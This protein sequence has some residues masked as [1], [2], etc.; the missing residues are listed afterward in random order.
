MLS[1]A[2]QLFSNEFDMSY[3]IPENGIR[4]PLPLNTENRLDD[5]CNKSD[6]LFK[7][8]YY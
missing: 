5:K 6:E 8:V 2:V 3:Q 1:V 7:V 4:P